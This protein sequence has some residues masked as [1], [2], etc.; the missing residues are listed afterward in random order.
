MKAV[1]T[2]GRRKLMKQ[3]TRGTSSDETDQ[4]M[5]EVA[6]CYYEQRLT[7]EQIARRVNT[8]RSTVSRLLEEA[9][10][11]GMVHIKINYPWQRDPEIE[12]QLVERFGLDE[13]RVLVGRQRPEEET[14]RGTGELTAQLI[15]GKVKDGQI[16]GIS[17]GRSLASTVAALD[18]KRKVALEVVPVI[19]ATGSENPSID[20]PDLV[21]R[22]ASAYGGKYRQLPVP[23]L[24]EN[25]QTRD[26]LVQMPKIHE[27]LNLARRADIVLLGIGA[28]APQH[29]SA[30]WKGYLDERNLTRIESQ[31]AV[32]HICGQFYDAQGQVLDIEVNRRA[33]GIGIQSLPGI[34]IVIA[35]ASG[36]D[37]TKAILGAL[38]GKYL[39][40]LVTDDAT[41][42]AVLDSSETGLSEQMCMT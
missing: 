4:L 27:V 8:S 40:V 15:D 13:A 1:E 22:F 7:Q 38:R 2:R 25:V 3:N 20:G 17:F 31:G 18:P 26:A 6:I 10:N 11:R 39:N 16:F 24:V 9:R 32:G 29:A 23:L 14:R 21:R 35:V 30:I 5:L 19:G 36:T 12:Q 33:I 42:T 37:K 28:V 41:A 34:E